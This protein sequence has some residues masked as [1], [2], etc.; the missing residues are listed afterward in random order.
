[1]GCRRVVRAGLAIAAALVVPAGASG[2]DGMG[3]GPTSARARAA[4]DRVRPALERDLLALGVRVGAPLFLRLHKAEA[5]LELFV[6]DGMRYLRF[7]RYPIC[8]YSGALGPKLREGDGQ[9]PEGFYAVR[10]EQL[11]PASRFHLA[12]DL[13]FPNAYDRALGRTGSYLMVHGDCVSIGCYAMGDAAIEEIYTLVEAALRGGQPAVPVHIFPFRMDGTG[14][15][16]NEDARWRDFWEN[17]REGWLA[18]ERTGRPPAVGVR[19]GRYVFDGGS[20]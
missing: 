3:E 10:L 4:A 11:N 17:L 15:G 2:A 9:A 7:R 16:A 13:G 5:E 20:P 14:R 18:F 19:D 12:F 1:M 6:D 8:A